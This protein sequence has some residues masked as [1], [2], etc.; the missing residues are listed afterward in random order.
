MGRLLQVISALGSGAEHV[1][2]VDNGSRNFDEGRLCE[3]R[4]ALR[5]RRLATNLGIAAAQNEGVRLA[6]ERG[7]AYVLFLDQDSIP[8][9]GMVA[10]LRRTYDRLEAQG[11]KVALV[12]PR[13]RMRDM[14]KVSDFA[15][16]GC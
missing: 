6:R 3:L 16:I 2:L 15:R 8:Q 12:G 9:S 4:P 5:I 10:C 14:T 1:V 7:A 11:C 13:V